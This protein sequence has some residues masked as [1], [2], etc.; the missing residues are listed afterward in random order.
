MAKHAY[1]IMVHN[2]AGLVNE[3][4]TLLDDSRNDIFLHVDLKADD[5]Y[6]AS[7][8]RNLRF[9]SIYFSKR[10]RVS[11]GGFSQ[12]RAEISLLKQATDTGHYDYYH[13]IS[14]ADL[15]IKSQNQ[16]HQF[17]ESIQGLELVQFQQPQIDKQKLDR[18]QRYFLFQEH[19]IRHSYFLSLIQRTLAKGQRIFKVD[20]TKKSGLTFQMGSNWFSITD[21]FARYI[22][23]KYPHYEKYFR[24]TQCADELFIQTMLINSPFRKRLY[25]P[26]FDDSTQGNMRFIVWVNHAPRDL[27]IEDFESLKNTQ[28][29]FARKFNPDTDNQII[30]KVATELA[31]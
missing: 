4:L 1:L 5:N 14:G 30:Q 9:S 16:I 22:L 8:K 24:Y 6:V 17:F 13:L 27:V 2:H 21:D 11:W 3:L 15:P 12:I 28:L 31:K 19:D 23:A 18:V 7:L 10:V 20:R 29:L 25:H 26:E